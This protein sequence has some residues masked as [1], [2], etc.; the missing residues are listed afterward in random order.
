MSLPFRFLTWE[1]SYYFS[2]IL[3]KVTKYP[4]IFDDGACGIYWWWSRH[5]YN[6]L[7]SELLSFLG[8]PTSSNWLD[9]FKVLNDVIKSNW[10]LKGTEIIE[11]RLK[12]MIHLKRNTNTNKFGILLNHFD[13]ILLH[14]FDVGLLTR[15]CARNDRIVHCLGF[16]LAWCLL[17]WSLV[18]IYLY[19]PVFETILSKWWCNSVDVKCTLR[20]WF[21]Q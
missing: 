9:Y 18:L 2:V 10:I 12:L 8:P 19:C 7:Y 20:L 4:S 3:C 16:S 11:L 1:I 6:L 14:D 17:V 15:I 21:F 13:K 5:Y